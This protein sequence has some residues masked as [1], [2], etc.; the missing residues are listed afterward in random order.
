ME[1]GMAPKCWPCAAHGAV[2]GGA[3]GCCLPPRGMPQAVAAAARQRLARQHGR[4]KCVYCNEAPGQIFDSVTFVCLYSALH[5]FQPAFQRVTFVCLYSALHT[6]QPVLL[7]LRTSVGKGSNRQDGLE[8]PNGA[9][10][11]KMDAC[12]SRVAAWQKSGCVCTS[13]RLGSAFEQDVSCKECAAA[14]LSE[15]GPT[16]DSEIIRTCLSAREYA[17]LPARWDSHVR[18]RERP[19]ITLACASATSV[20]QRRH[21][22]SGRGTIGAASCRGPL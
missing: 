5:T 3:C 13:G 19:T 12:E 2:C 9:R 14:V 10:A 22:A 6:F 18:S 17:L 8:L 1:M 16:T 7:L 4:A 15:P 11:W 21:A 20:S